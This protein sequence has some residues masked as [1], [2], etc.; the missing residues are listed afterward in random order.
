MTETARRLSV[1]LRVQPRFSPGVRDFRVVSSDEREM[2]FELTIHAS[3]WGQAQA[4]GG[5]ALAEALQAAGVT[6]M[7]DDAGSAP[8]AP[9]VQS[10][11]IMLTEA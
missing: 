4:L 10:L 2:D 1:W 7:L 5:A 11:G 8:G 6:L 9:Y 3:S